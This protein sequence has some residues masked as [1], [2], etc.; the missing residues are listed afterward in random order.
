[1]I[2]KKQMDKELTKI[3][4]VGMFLGFLI[5]VIFSTFIIADSLDGQVCG[6]VCMDSV[7]FYRIF[8]KWKEAKIMQT[9]CLRG[10]EWIDVEFNFTE[11]IGVEEM[12][13]FSDKYYGKFEAIRQEHDEYFEILEGAYVK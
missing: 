3:G 1:M 7:D 12:K 13:N 4:F 11:I 2:T 10:I 9:Q 6:D 5:G 8:E